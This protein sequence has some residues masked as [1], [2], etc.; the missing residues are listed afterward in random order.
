M[1]PLK[2]AIVTVALFVTFLSLNGFC[3]LFAQNPNYPV[4]Y[5]EDYRQ[6]I[7][8]VFANMPL[9]HQV[10]SG[11]LADYGVSF[12]NLSHYTGTPPLPV[13]CFKHFWGCGES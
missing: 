2:N 3:R 10:P 11:L 12:A 6:K 13:V 8:H 9:H 5:N 4:T 7:N 1:K